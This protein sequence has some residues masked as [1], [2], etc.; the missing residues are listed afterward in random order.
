ML[1][2]AHGSAE[3]LLPEYRGEVARLEL[4]DLGITQPDGADG[5]YVGHP[6]SLTARVLVEAEPFDAPLFFGL[7][8]GD[9]HCVVG[10]VGL[11]HLTEY[12]EAAARAN[13][14]IATHAAALDAGSLADCA[15]DHAGC[16]DDEECVGLIGAVT[17]EGYDPDAPVDPDAEF[18]VPTDDAPPVGGEATTVWQCM[19]PAYAGNLAAASETA[20]LVITPADLAGS[21]ELEYA[22]HGETIVPEACA[23]LAGAAD[24][25]A[26]ASFD[27]DWLTHFPA[28]VGGQDE[29]HTDLD[30]APGED[31]ELDLDADREARAFAARESLSVTVGALA[32]DPG[33]D[34]ELRHLTTGSAVVALHE[35]VAQPWDFDVT[36]E[37][38]VD[39]KLDAEHEAALADARE[40][41][42]FTLRP[43]GDARGGCEAGEAVDLAAA[44]LAIDD[45]EGHDDGDEVVELHVART[46]EE[47]GFALHI[48]SPVRERVVSGD[49]SCWDRFE[50]EA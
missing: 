12:F 31:A 5:L 43:F 18:V 10:E 16:G 11:E 13:Q 39:G 21:V 30:E 15:A 8:S 2:L 45:P 26:W 6:V 38:S 9:R 34:I 17:P 47:H 50:V 22:L 32:V 14:A 7:A 29:T 35:D 25:V 37:L 44:P 49:W 41:F 24:V 48:A 20:P 4:L 28:R 23:A 33:V 3:H 42:T 1:D 19:R 40:D 27:P 46:I 36:V